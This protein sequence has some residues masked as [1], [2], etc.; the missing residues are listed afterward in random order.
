M[1]LKPRSIKNL[2]K[3]KKGTSLVEV[4][5]AGSIL[6]VLLISIMILSVESADISKRVNYEYAANNIA[7]SRIE[8]ARMFIENN[9][10]DSLTDAKYGQTNIRL[11]FSGVPDISGDFVRSTT[12]VED[13]NS[14]ERLTQVT[15]TVKYYYKGI[16]SSSPLVCST[17]FSRIDVVVP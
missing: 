6:S 4:V 2:L 1:F 14:N 12:V 5:F 10:F 16:L 17:V 13:Y 15:V 3:I 7:K 9:G 11:D 8:D